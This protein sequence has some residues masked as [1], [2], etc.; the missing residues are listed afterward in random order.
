MNWVHVHIAHLN[1][2]CFLDIEGCFSHI[3]SRLDIGVVEKRPEW[4]KKT[5]RTGREGNTKPISKSQSVRQ[6]RAICSELKWRIKSDKS[7]SKEI[8]PFTLTCW[9][10]P[11]CQR[12]APGYAGRSLFYSSLLFRNWLLHSKY[13]SHLRSTRKRVG[14]SAV[15]DNS[16]IA[17]SPVPV[18]LRL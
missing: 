13:I 12:K 9:T 3:G 4:M 10:L 1:R 11:R 16:N 18:Y 17:V 5:K 6:A 2:Y 14:A 8:M 7:R 15:D